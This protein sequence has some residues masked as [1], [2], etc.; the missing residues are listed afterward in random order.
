MSISRRHEQ[1]G[2]PIHPSAFLREDF[3]GPLELSANA[4]AL[5]LH[6]PVTRIAEILRERRGITADMARRLARHFGT[7][8]DFGM[9]MP[10]S[11]DRALAS[12][13][14]WRAS[15]SRFSPPPAAKQE[16]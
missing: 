12:R 7:T 14:S 8:L 3:L 9:K 16:N 13:E 6:V 11:Y 10:M 5:A 1:R 2:I 15:K 4:L